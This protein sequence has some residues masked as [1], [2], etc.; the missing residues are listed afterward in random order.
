[1]Q[2][3]QT[4]SLIKIGL[5]P[6]EGGRPSKVFDIETSAERLVRWSVDGSALTYVRTLNGISTLLSQPLS[7][8]PAHV[9]A[10][11]ERDRIFSFDWSP[12]GKKLA[13]SRGIIQY[14]V[15]QV[16]KFY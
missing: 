8:K 10:D 7:G 11:F 1:M 16:T 3:E 5:F 6:F 14:D 15:V 12:D 13:V 2:N 4:N 9:I